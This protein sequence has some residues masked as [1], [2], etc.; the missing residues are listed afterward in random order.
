MYFISICIYDQKRINFIII[1]LHKKRL[2]GGDILCGIREG[3]APS[4]LRS[5]FRPILTMRTSYRHFLYRVLR[6]V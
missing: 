3:D 5:E 2:F 6:T 1:H 4:P